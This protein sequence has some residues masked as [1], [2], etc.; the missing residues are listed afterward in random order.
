MT[1]AT[2][3]GATSAQRS[4]LNFTSPGLDSSCIPYFISVLC[5]AMG[6]SGDSAPEAFPHH[7]GCITSSLAEKH[8]LDHERPF[9]CD[10]TH[11][12][13]KRGAQFPGQSPRLTSNCL[14]LSRGCSLARFHSVSSGFSRL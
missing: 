6:Q 14:P 4:F 3:I 12:D 11:P 5:H 1:R 7:R 2:V 9:V 10:G 13:Y 8:P